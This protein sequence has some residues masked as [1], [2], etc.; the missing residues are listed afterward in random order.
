MLKDWMLSCLEIMLTILLPIATAYLVAF[1]KNKSDQLIDQTDNEKSK[2]YIDEVTN[3]ITTAVIY[4]SQTYVDSLKKNGAFTKQAQE[5][6]LA[7][8]KETAISIISPAAA[9][10][11]N[12][13]YG[14]LETYIEPKIEETVRVQKVESA[15]TQNINVV[16]PETAVV[17][18]SPV[19]EAPASVDLE[20]EDNYDVTGV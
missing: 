9:D 15:P 20:E 19:Q 10:F 12:E 6:A 14:D 18:E 8:A 5:K 3:A 11:I 4:T 13:V 2:H 16:V 1:L 7:K 17:A